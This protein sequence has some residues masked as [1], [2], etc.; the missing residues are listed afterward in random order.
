[1]NTVSF[2]SIKRTLRTWIHTQPNTWTRFRVWQ[3]IHPNEWFSPSWQS[4]NLIRTPED[5]RKTL[6]GIPHSISFEH[7]EQVTR[8]YPLRISP[9]YLNLIHE[10]SYADPIFQQAIPIHEEVRAVAGFTP[11]PFKETEKSPVPGLIH[12]YPDRVLLIVSNLC[13]TFCRHCFRKRILGKAGVPTIWKEISR[14]LSYIENH[15]EIHDVILS[16]GDPLTIPVKKLDWLLTK[17]RS[18]SHIH[19]LRIGTRTPVTLPMAIWRLSLLKVFM[20]HAPIWLLTHVN[21]PRELTPAFQITVTLLRQTGC[22]V[23][24][25]CVLLKNINDSPAT[26]I[27]LH[28]NLVRFG[29]QPYYLHYADPAQGTHHF[30]TSLRKGLEIMEAMRGKLSGIAIPTFVVD[31]PGGHGKVP[32]YPSYLIGRTHTSWLICSPTHECIPY[33]PLN[34]DAHTEKDISPVHNE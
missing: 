28:R 33:P 3:F 16:G 25:Q 10:F 8:I 15:T 30:R 1:M 24:N 26:M 32:V 5:L 12:R 19:V 2:Q 18:I 9:Y 34:D 22:I 29:V 7:I 20:K 31:L 21:H 4:R 11:D 6:T 17:L 27:E 14:V 23:L 13:S